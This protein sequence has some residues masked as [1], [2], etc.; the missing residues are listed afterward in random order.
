MLSRASCLSLLWVLLIH[1]CPSSA[2]TSAVDTDLE[3]TTSLQSHVVDI[4]VALKSLGHPLPA[5][6]RDQLNVLSS[7]PATPD[8]E[9]ALQKLIDPYS[10]LEVEVLPNGR[11]NLRRG[12]AQPILAQGGWKNYLVKVINPSG[13]TGEL[14]IVSPNTEPLYHKSKGGQFPLPEN[15]MTPEE[16]AKRFLEVSFFRGRPLGS[17]LSRAPLEYRILQ[18][19]TREKL[20]RHAS[21]SVRLVEDGNE[22]G[23]GNVSSP[24]AITFEVTPATKVIFQILDHD[25]SPAMAGLTIS[26]GI[27][28]FVR[29]DSDSP[30]PNNY[31]H[32][33]ALRRPWERIWQEGRYQ[34][35][36]MEGERLAGIYPLP[37]QRLATR[38]LFPDF[39]F[40]AQI[41]RQDGEFVYLPAGDYDI[42]FSR[43]PEYIAQHQKIIVGRDRK[44][45]KAVFQLKRWTNLAEQG[46]YSSD[47]HVHASGC[48]HYETP[49]TGVPP[50][51]IWRQSL[52]EDLNV[53]AV[54]NWGVGWYD[55]KQYF[56]RQFTQPLTTSRN[57]LRYDVEVS[58]F[59]SAH[60]GHLG[61]WDLKDD[62]YPGTQK[63]EDWPSWTLP[64]LQWAKSQGAVTGYVHTGW[65]MEPD[66]STRLLPNYILPNYVLPKMNGIGANEYVVTVVEGVVD[67]FGVGDTT[68][69]QELNTWYHALNAGFRSRLSGE[70][71]FPC[72]YHERIGI[73]RGY[74]KL[75]KALNFSNY[76]E[77]MKAGRSYVSD[78]RSH[79]VDFTVD[80]TE[81]GTHNSE[82]K[83]AQTKEVVIR[84]KVTGY[85]SEKQ[86]T[87]GRF[88]ANSSE[89]RQPAWDI[90]RARIGQT[91]KVMVELVVNGVPVESREL[92]ADGTWQDVKFIQTISMSSWIAVRIYPSSHTN[93]IFVIVD[94]QPVRA[95]RR[96]AQ[97][98]RSAVDRLWDVKSH[99]IREGEKADALEQYL[100]AKKIYDEIISDSVFE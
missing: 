74:A 39:Y 43:G 25:G 24:V 12:Q 23:I 31:R 77:Q 63:I 96:S 9:L 36:V 94:D 7:R 99:D 78:G 56:D 51:F 18:I 40:Q 95:S 89:Q 27:Q 62:D 93:P 34:T 68:P 26:D 86:N 54:M 21:L 1:S 52:G 15:L 38:D 3:N 66:R 42:T 72:I 29:S 79:I 4:G 49:E 17:A 20:S 16:L 14:A 64:I 76:M 91:R 13:I 61:L 53:T 35:R 11:L 22:R 97:W 57:L 10:L 87:L 70:S 65:G 88:I 8:V 80:G 92:E 2:K 67:L 75:N 6:L 58:H 50:E 41:Y 5:K 84:A 60:L 45:Q 100:K 48:K 82:V 71:D 85:L 32:R 37:S 69:V 55:Q 90:E 30:L 33:F 59:P 44:E 46:W 98:L 81:L 28:R 19:Y 47:L 83:I 73:A